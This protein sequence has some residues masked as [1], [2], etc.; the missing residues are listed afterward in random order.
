MKRRLSWRRAASMVLV[1]GLVLLLAG[2]RGR[3]S[4]SVTPG[5]DPLETLDLEIKPNV[6]IIL[7]SSGSMNDTPGNNTI[8]GDHPDSKIGAAKRVLLQAIQNNETKVNF[9]YGTYTQSTST[10]S[11]Q[12]DTLGNTGQ[13]N[14]RF[15]Y[16]AKID[17]LALPVVPELFLNQVYAFQTISNAGSVINNILYFDEGGATFSC[18]ITPGFYASGAA[19][20]TQLAANMNACS[21]GNGYTVTFAGGLFAFAKTGVRSFRMD[22]SQAVNSIRAVLN[23]GTTNT[24]LGAGPFTT[25]NAQGGAFLALRHLASD[26]AFTENGLNYRE[27]VAG[28]FWNGQTLFVLGITGTVCGEAAAVTPTNPPTVNL[29]Q[30]SNCASPTASQVGAPLVFTF[31]GGKARLNGGGGWGGN[32]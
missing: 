3:A 20:A 27:M 24:G 23:A 18:A 4:V 22:W 16:W 14:D 21:A 31:A 32:A 17:P 25:G 10:T 29:Q 30:V 26:L 7:D 8:G 1:G 5:I 28:K 13:G 11:Q 15:S 6:I 2:D 12:P 19:L 9:M